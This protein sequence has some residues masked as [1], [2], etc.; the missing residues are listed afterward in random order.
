M[1]Y[2]R[3]INLFIFHSEDIWT[4]LYLMLMCSQITSEYWWKERF[5]IS[6]YNNFKSRVNVCHSY[7]VGSGSDF[8]EFPVICIYAE[9]MFFQYQYHFE[10]QINCGSPKQKMYKAWN[11]ISLSFSPL[12]LFPPHCTI[13]H[14]R[15]ELPSCLRVEFSNFTIWNL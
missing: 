9:K 15:R 4:L 7:S 6:H 5:V 2:C 1:V 8:C 14:F 3:L 10:P 12:F 13:N 11:K